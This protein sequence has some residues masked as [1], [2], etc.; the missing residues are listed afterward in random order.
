MSR[1]MAIDKEFRLTCLP[2]ACTSG[3]GCAATFLGRLTD[4]AT[5]TTVGSAL[6]RGLRR[7]VGLG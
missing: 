5:G 4:L 3:V 6:E 2:V 7:T 1:V